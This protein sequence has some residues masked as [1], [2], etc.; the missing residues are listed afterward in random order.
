MA[1]RSGSSPEFQ[2]KVRAARRARDTA[3][4]IEALDYPIEAPLAARYLGEL[5]AVEAVPWLLALLASPDPHARAAGATALGSLR[6]A[7]A[8]SLLARLA[9][10]DPVPWVRSWA[11]GALVDVG[12][13]EE[14]RPLLHRAL[15]DPDAR[16][17][18]TAVLRLG[19]TGRA[20][21]L[22]R[23][24]EAEPAE[25]WWL[26]RNYRKARSRIESRARQA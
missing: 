20:S 3:F 18:R 1:G 8:A 10:T 15:H 16:V 11:L 17:R 19:A 13:V 2:R 26:R 12:A 9:E 22:Q 4:L 6:A 5:G 14:I 25:K 7:R 24:R 21:D 23:L